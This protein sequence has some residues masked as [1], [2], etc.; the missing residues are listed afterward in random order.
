VDGTRV[1]D[2]NDNIVERSY[3]TLDETGAQVWRSILP[4][5]YVYD[6]KIETQR[7]NAYDSW[8]NNSSEAS[9]DQP[10]NDDGHE[11]CGKGGFHSCHDNPRNIYLQEGEDHSVNARYAEWNSVS[12]TESSGCS[13]STGEGTSQVEGDSPRVEEDVERDP[14]ETWEQFRGGANAE[15]DGYAFETQE[16]ANARRQKW[17]QAA[18]RRK[19]L[20]SR[21]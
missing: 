10:D 3:M 14:E 9:S 20:T 15:N 17:E 21:P 2:N 8:Y 7:D 4:Q 16:L 5:G 1:L 11:D 19:L 6:E 12:E 13:N 18:Q